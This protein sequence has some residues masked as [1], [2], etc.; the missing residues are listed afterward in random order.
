M[1]AVMNTDVPLEDDGRPAPGPLRRIRQA[2]WL[3]E[4]LYDAQAVLGLVGI[5]VL[6][7]L[8]LPWL[9]GVAEAAGLDDNE[10]FRTVVIALVLTSVL[11]QLRDIA[12]ALTKSRETA[13]QLMK[14]QTLA[15]TQLEELR[16]QQRALETR[17]THFVNPADMYEALLANARSLDDATS[18]RL[19]VLG[20][21]LF[22]AWPQLSFWLQQPE[23]DGWVVT[24]ATLDPGYADPHIPEDWPA[25]SRLN[26]AA[27]RTFAARRSVVDRGIE[28][29]V[30]TY[31]FVPAVHGFRLGN[32]DLYVSVLLWDEAGAVGK[33]GF[34]YEYVP[35]YAQSATAESY[36]RL[37]D[38]WFRRALSD[39]LEPR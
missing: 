35:H 28:I 26:A 38:N 5:A 37:Y 33:E 8:Q 23:A 11:L 20:L 21:T 18:K 16:R 12:Q 24:L 29:D 34:S 1:I 10:K 36:R 39:D 4:R 25:E 19:D 17:P 7:L 22:S 3:L 30:R 6:L 32:G 15:S 27:A 2:G 14:V 31:A 9:G 13:E